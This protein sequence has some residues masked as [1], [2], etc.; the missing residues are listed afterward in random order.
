MKRRKS[1]LLCSCDQLN[2][3]A[4][5]SI[6]LTVYFIFLGSGPFTTTVP[7]SSWRNTT[8]EKVL[9]VISIRSI[10]LSLIIRLMKASA[11][12]G[13]FKLATSINSLV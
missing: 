5:A 12:A 2:C 4:I 6:S 11:L 1:L 3:I 13:V 10:S 7:L 8:Y 9:G